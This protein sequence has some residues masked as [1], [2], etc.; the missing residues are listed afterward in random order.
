MGVHTKHSVDLEMIQLMRDL[1]SRGTALA[2]ASNS[3]KPWIESVWKKIDDAPSIDTII[4]PEMG[5]AK[6]AVEYFSH[7]IEEIHAKPTE[8]F[9]VDDRQANCEAATQAGLQ[10]YWYQGDVV[11]LR[12]KLNL[13]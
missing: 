11:A 5:A 8:V 12:Q 13:T 6:P 4:T 7:L 3:G 1:Q 2:L 9:F 10:S